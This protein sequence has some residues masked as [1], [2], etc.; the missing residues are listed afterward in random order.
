MS[1]RVRVVCLILYKYSLVRTSCSASQRVCPLVCRPDPAMCR[2]K[3]LKR[4]LEIAGPVCR[5]SL[6]CPMLRRTDLLLSSSS[7]HPHSVSWRMSVNSRSQK[8]LLDH[9]G[10]RLSIN[11]PG[12]YRRSTIES[13]PDVL[14]CIARSLCLSLPSTTLRL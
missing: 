11:V 10:P 7:A 14:I 5:S 13:R 12:L 6:V 3:S 9:E 1:Y 8:V 4:F 2:R